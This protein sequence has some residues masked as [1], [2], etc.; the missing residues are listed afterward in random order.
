MRR[1]RWR[2]CGLVGG[3]ALPALALATLLTGLS[4]AARTAADTQAIRGGQAA[5]SG[6]GA[7][8]SGT[9]LSAVSCTRSN[10]CMAVGSS[11]TP[12]RGRRAVAEIWNGTTWRVLKD[13]PGQSM[14]GVTCAAPWF[15]MTQGTAG[16]QTWEGRRWH[17]VPGP[18]EQASPITCGGHR[19]CAVLGTGTEPSG[20]VAEI[21]TGSTWRAWTAKTSECLGY[22]PS[23]PCGLAGIS[24]GNAVNCMAVGTATVDQAGDQW[25]ES[26][27][28]NG[29]TW[30]PAFTMP[31]G[32]EP[33]AAYA[34]SCASYF[35][36]A[37]GGADQMDTDG[38]IAGA[39]TWTANAGWQDA[40]PSLGTICPGYGTC[41]WTGQLSCGSAT[42]C[43]T[44]GRFGD[45]DW[46]GS[47]WN[48]D[49]TI[50]AGP[51]SHLT[52]LSCHGAI[53]MAVGTQVVNRRN[54]SLAEL[55]DG[56]SWSIV[57][58]PGAS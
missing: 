32:G 46:N 22:P 20:D 38:D 56:S 16:T 49:P 19:L 28:W 15:C 8:A 17:R 33:A 25:G 30:R 57:P 50:S 42:N 45:L 36:M 52:G 7:A 53:C 24:C 4:G 54:E 41:G 2:A 26:V 51:G 40:S 35:C 43:M 10:W 39:A 31:W 21:W 18:S 48:S 44:F 58:V 12:S 3:L 23:G 47:A 13:A 34:V 14:R 37:V 11:A 55:F 29:V 5:R 27:D 9:S 1:P 6:Q